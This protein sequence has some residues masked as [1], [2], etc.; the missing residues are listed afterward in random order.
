MNTPSGR[1]AKSRLAHDPAEPI[2]IERVPLYPTCM[3]AQGIGRG[4]ADLVGRDK[5]LHG[6]F[7]LVQS[8]ISLEL[9]LGKG[10]A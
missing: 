2:G 5:A 3:E 1:T 8:A 4:L 10:A 6:V 7:A 9:C